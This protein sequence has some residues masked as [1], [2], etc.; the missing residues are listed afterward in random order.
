MA[1]INAREANTDLQMTGV[2]QHPLVGLWPGYCSNY[3]CI[4]NGFSHG[5]RIRSNKYTQ[6]FFAEILP[7]SCL[8]VHICGVITSLL[9]IIFNS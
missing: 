1:F 7:P 6:L 5:S 2:R 3:L 9:F 4:V 8:C